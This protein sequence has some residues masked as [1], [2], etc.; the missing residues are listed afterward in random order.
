MKETISKLDIIKIKNF[1][2][3]RDGVNRTRQATDWEKIFAN[4]RSLSKT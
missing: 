3:E 1:Y 4:K 2:S